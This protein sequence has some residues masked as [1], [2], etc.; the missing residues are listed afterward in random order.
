MVLCTGAEGIAV[1]MSTKILPHNMIEV[2]EAEKS[3]LLGKSFS[4]NPDFQTGG[5]IDVSDYREGNGKI[6][7]RANIDSSDPKRLVIRELPAGSTTESLIL[8]IENA[9]KAGRIKIQGISDYTTEKVEIEIKLSRGVY[10]EET[11]D[12]LYAFT[13]CEQS[14]SVNLLVIKNNYPVIMTVGEIVRYHAKMLVGILVKELELEKKELLDRLHL[15]TLERI[16]IEERVYKAIENKK[17]VETVIKSVIDG[18]KPFMK[19][20]YFPPPAENKEATPNIVT[21]DDVE[22]L[23]KIPIRRIS[24]YDINKARAEMD[25]IK[26]RVKEINA[27]L[28][29]R[30]EYAIA[31]IDSVIKK[32]KAS[33]ELGGGK[34]RSEVGVFKKIDVKEVIRKDINL[35]YDR[36]TGYLGTAI[37]DGEII[38]GLSSFDRVF[39][40]RNNG[41]YSVFDIPEKMFVGENACYIGKADKDEIIAKVFTVIYKDPATGYPYIKRC[42]LEG[43]IMN[44]EYSIIPESAEGA[45]V[46]LASAEKKFSFVLNYTPKPRLKTTSEKFKS[47]DFLVKGAKSQGVRLANKEVASAAVA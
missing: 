8:S 29:K 37:N 9:A 6:L 7:T 22:S 16:F 3:C 24:L 15:R 18:F 32:V 25:E 31:Y 39:A 46:L 33:E 45:E 26:A 34:R 28:K 38:E 11:I 19:D 1:G 21:P 12:A 13:E 44:K 36:K 4:L 27:H 2:L 17:T 35:R 41:M 43:W 42:G 40:M 5:L 14:I 23:L 30:T 20:I 47:A 10:S